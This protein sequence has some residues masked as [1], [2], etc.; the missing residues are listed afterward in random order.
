GWFIRLNCAVQALRR[1]G[2]SVHPVE[3]PLQGCR[4]TATRLVPP[5]EPRRQVAPGAGWF[6]RLNCAVQASRRGGVSVH[7]VEPP[8]QGC[9]GTATRLVPPAEPR[10]QVAPGAGWFIRLNCAVQASRRGGVSVH[11]VEPPL[12]GCRGTATR[13]VHP[14]EPRHP[15]V[16]A[17]RGCWFTRLNCAV[18]ARA[19]F[20]R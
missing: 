4:G 18:E 2:V 12:Q 20:P 13:L 10:S 3:P 11:P 9:R 17:Q 15:G 1:G 6:I 19:D 14:A 7:P 16:K 5:A 8:L